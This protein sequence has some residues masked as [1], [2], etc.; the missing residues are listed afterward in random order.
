MD[1]CV[2]QYFGQNTAFRKMDLT[3]SSGGKLKKIILSSVG[4]NELIPV[5]VELLKEALFKGPNLVFF[6][7][8][9]IL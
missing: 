1:L 8:C 5:K 2:V 6:Y 3:Q 4:S 7:L 9:L